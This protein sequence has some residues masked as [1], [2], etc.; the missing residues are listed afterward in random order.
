MAKTL[1]KI[2]KD[3]EKLVTQMQGIGTLVQQANDSKKNSEMQSEYAAQEA[4]NQAAK[5]RAGGHQ[6]K[7][8]ADFKSEKD[9]LSEGLLALAA[10]QPQVYP[11]VI[12][13]ADIAQ[14][15]L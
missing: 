11:A 13:A 8:L 4:G 2:S 7:T 3:Y 6:G 15:G 1:D 5:L 14:A 9:I 10:A 12:A